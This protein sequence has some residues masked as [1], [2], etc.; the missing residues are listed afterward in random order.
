METIRNYLENMFASLPNTESVRTAKDELLQMMEDKYNELISEGKTENEAVGTVISDFGNLD[1]LAESL[2]LT[3]EVN[4]AAQITKEIPRRSVYIDEV[5]EYLHAKAQSGLKIGIG[6][7]LCITCVCFP[8]IGDVTIMPEWLYICGMFLMIV[9]AVAIF[10][11]NGTEMSKWK[12]LE[13]QLC[14]I[15]MMTSQYVDEQR[16]NYSTTHALRLSIG[17]ALCVI[18]WLPCVVFDNIQVLENLG[19]VALFVIVGIGVLMII[20]TSTINESFEKILSLNDTQMISGHYVDKKVEYINPGV[21]LMM[22]VF[23]PVTTCIYLAWSFLSF[24][25][26]ITWIIW[27][28]AAIIHAVFK[29]VLSVK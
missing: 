24:D 9:L 23:W 12:Y 19:A 5:K 1:E 7:F 21:S 17:V 26:H 29:S 18:C 3:K 20:Q 16:K 10:I 2:G 22:E 4:E 6:V 28:I 13:S 25:W 14:Q 27:P 8:I 11:F 15:D